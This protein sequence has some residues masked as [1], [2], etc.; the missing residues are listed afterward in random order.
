M[1]SGSVYVHGHICNATVMLAWKAHAAAQEGFMQLHKVLTDCITLGVGNLLLVMKAAG[2]AQMARP[3][4]DGCGGGVDLV[5]REQGV[6]TDK[7]E[8]GAGDGIRTHDVLLGGET[9]YR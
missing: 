2:I 5:V 9:L 8:V 3:V 6:Q 4:C 1:K 7:M